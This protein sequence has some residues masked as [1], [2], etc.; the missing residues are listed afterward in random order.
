MNIAGLFYRIATGF[1]QSSCTIIGRSIGQGSLKEAK[2]YY[3]LF[4][5]LSVGLSGCL[6]LLQYIFQQ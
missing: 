4:C 2:S 5:V 3:Y 6:A 1:E